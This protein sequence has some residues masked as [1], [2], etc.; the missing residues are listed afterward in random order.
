MKKKYVIIGTSATGFNALLQLK[1]I[2]PHASIIGIT[3][4]K[5]LPYNKCFLADFIAYQKSAAEIYLPCDLSIQENLL[6]NT[7]VTAIFP[8]EKRI[9]VNNVS[10][11]E[12]D[13][14]LI[15]TG[16]RPFI[17]MAFQHLMDK[18]GISTFHTLFD[19]HYI[20]KASNSTPII[21]VGAG[22]NGLECA[23]ALRKADKKVIIIEQNPFILPSLQDE[24][25][26]EIVQK[27]LLK[28]GI[29]CLTQTAITQVITEDNALKA[30]QL[31]DGSIIETAQLV[32]A[33]GIRP[34][35]P[36]PSGLSEKEGKILTNSFLQTS[37][38]A[39][40]AGGDCAQINGNELTTFLS[41]NH[42]SSAVLQGITAAFN[43]AG[44]IRPL[45]SLPSF[46]QTML[47]NLPLC[48]GG[49]PL[50]PDGQSTYSYSNNAYQ[51]IVLDTKGH[52]QG[53]VL[54][55]KIEKGNL[56]RKSLT[57]K[58]FNNV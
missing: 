5:E 8:L 55:D 51:K 41:S 28:Y 49:D 23:D 2:D 27:H 53:F 21:V 52:L 30:I 7:T 12:Y 24:K 16:T 34:C 10:S 6:L 42:W 32:I 54:I 26:S 47:C 57:K 15:A 1:R 45:N 17:P 4:E 18:K 19:A 29:S 20:H 9:M 25:V 58:W 39:I 44:Y 46:T 36:S 56:L 40:Y 33:T 48:W 11:I 22:I 3:Q 35:I 50:F 13:K 37:N 43:M 14:L 38:H 31:N